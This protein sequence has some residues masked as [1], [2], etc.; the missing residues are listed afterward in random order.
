MDFQHWEGFWKEPGVTHG[1]IVVFFTVDDPNTELLL[2]PAATG[3]PV[4]LKGTV[5]PCTSQGGLVPK[6]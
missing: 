6:E 3:P 4:E 5:A 2:S 1:V